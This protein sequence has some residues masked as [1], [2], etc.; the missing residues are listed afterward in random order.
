MIYFLAG[1][2][3]LKKY[4]LDK[5]TVISFISELEV[6]SGPNLNAQ[7]I[8]KAKI[9]ISKYE[10]VGYLP[11]I[12]DIVID[13]RS[14]KRIKLADAI[15]AATAIYLNYPLVSADKGFFGIEGLDFIY[16]EPNLS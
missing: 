9:L 16:H 4:F 13:I 12:K 3:E 2:I 5:A 14:K 10:V 7:S 11:E 6:L 8:E 15:I 1:H